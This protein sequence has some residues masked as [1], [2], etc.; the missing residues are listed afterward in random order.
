MIQI[1][2]IY[3]IVNKL[4]GKCYIGQSRDIFKRYK[5]HL[6]HS[7]SNIDRVIHEIG[8]EYFDLEILDFCDP[9]DQQAL[10]HLEE[11]YITIYN[12][13]D[14]EYGY[15]ISIG[16]SS[17]KGDRNNN[18]KLNS[19]EVFNIREAYKNHLSQSVTYDQYKNKISRS[20]FNAVWEGRSWDNI[21]M[22]VYTDENINY[23]KRGTS[24]GEKSVSAKFTDSEVLALRARYVEETANQIYDNIKDRC[25]YQTLQ[26]ILWGRYYSHLP[27][28]DKKHKVWINN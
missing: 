7:K 6:Y 23:Y 17:S 28:Y 5:E 16:G 3:R 11:M 20:E 12:S 26:Q 19:Q 10:D 24:I 4:N 25:G 27:I 15:N 9:L 13:S 14:P 21:H 2:G 22:D 18:S 8:I 1:C